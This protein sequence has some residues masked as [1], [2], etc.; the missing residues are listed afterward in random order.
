M[1]CYVWRATYDVLR[2]TWFCIIHKY[3]MLFPD[4]YFCYFLVAIFV[5]SWLLF[6]LFLDW[7]WCYFLIV[8]YVISWLLFM[9]L[10]DC[11]LCY[12]PDREELSRWR[13]SHQQEESTISRDMTLH[14]H[15]SP[16]SSSLPAVLCSSPPPR[17]SRCGCEGLRG[18]PQ[19]HRNIAGSENIQQTAALAYTPTVCGVDVLLKTHMHTVI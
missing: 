2:M 18:G 7:Y 8:I 6:M 13:W 17:C 5:I 9:L 15:A 3:I 11:Y 4:C 19:P 12:L 14:I 10:L 1:T 16:P